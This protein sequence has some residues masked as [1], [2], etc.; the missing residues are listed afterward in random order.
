MT[1][2]IAFIEGNKHLCNIPW[3]ILNFD[4]KRVSQEGKQDLVNSSALYLSNKIMY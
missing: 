4:E 1:A 3:V 2:D